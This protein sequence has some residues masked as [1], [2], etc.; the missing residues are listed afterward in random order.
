[1]RFDYH[2]EPSPGDEFPPKPV[3]PVQFTN[4]LTGESSVVY[5]LLDTG[6][7]ACHL[8]AS[9]IRDFGETDFEPWGIRVVGGAEIDTRAHVLNVN[10]CGKQFA[11]LDIVELP[12]GDDEPLL[13][14]NVLNKFVVKLNG[15]DLVCE[16]Q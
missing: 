6:A 7:D 9:I 1:M 13:G 8:P 3:V 10:L 4:P 16:I 12:E 5:C 14:R 2:V 11:E 15:P